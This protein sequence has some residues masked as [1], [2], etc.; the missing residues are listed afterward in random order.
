MQLPKQ[1]T[2][3]KTKS[4]SPSNKILQYSGL[5][6]QMLATIGLATWLG[7]KLDGWLEMKRF[8]AFT[9]LFVLMAVIGSLISLI[10]GLIK[11]NDDK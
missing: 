4:Q 1:P 10:R 6:F 9:I 8:P 5:G 3:P 11:E 2:D 7:I